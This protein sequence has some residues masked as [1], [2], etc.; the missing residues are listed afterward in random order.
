MRLSEALG[1][2]WDDVQLEH[3]FPHIDLKPHPWRRLKTSGNKRLIPLVGTSL[4]AVKTMYCQCDNS[5]YSNLMQVKVA[6]MATH[7]RQHSTSG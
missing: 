2:V 7:V 5:F 4:E 1:L 3:E 6:V